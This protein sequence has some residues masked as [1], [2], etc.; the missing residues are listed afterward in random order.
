MHNVDILLDWAGLHL[1]HH[2]VLLK[3]ALFN[4]MFGLQLNVETGDWGLAEIADI[5]RRLAQLKRPLVGCSC[6]RLL[7][8]SLDGCSY[9]VEA[10]GHNGNVHANRA[11]SDT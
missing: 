1:G 8:G 3:M 4:R 11:N 5:E 9:F 2:E 7:N 6:W 10:V